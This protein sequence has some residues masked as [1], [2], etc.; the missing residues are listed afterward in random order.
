MKGKFT[1]YL[2]F[3]LAVIMISC[4]YNNEEELYPVEKCDT[5]HVTYSASIVP[6]IEQNCYECH[7]QAAPISGIPLEGYANIKAMVDAGRIIGALRHQVGFSAM[8]KDRPSLP[9]CEILKIEKWIADGAP[10]N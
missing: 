7:E 6:I 8:P 5:T 1:C 3:Y 9:E 4:T 10:D 2:F